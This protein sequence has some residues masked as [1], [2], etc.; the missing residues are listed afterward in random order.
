MAYRNVTDRQTD[1]IAISISRATLVIGPCIT[2][3]ILEI[4]ITVSKTHTPPSE[5][6][7]YS[8]ANLPNPGIKWTVQDVLIPSELPRPFHPLKLV[9]VVVVV[10]PLGRYEQ[11]YVERQPCSDQAGVELSLGV[12]QLQ[13]RDRSHVPACRLTHSFFHAMLCM[14]VD[15][16]VTRCLS[17]CL[18]VCYTS[19]LCRNG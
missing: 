10:Q 1:I 16:A 18:S 19:A 7:S 5:S 3:L 17:V 2:W 6:L 9:G 13:S 14:S 11:V 12:H 4:K 15:Y 8:L